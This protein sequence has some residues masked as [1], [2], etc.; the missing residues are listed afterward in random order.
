MD[1]SFAD[2]FECDGDE[3]GAA[4]DAASSHRAAGVSERGGTP[5]R[6]AADDPRSSAV[7]ERRRLRAERE[8]ASL[9]AGPP[10]A[11]FGGLTEKQMMA[12]M[13]E[14]KAKVCARH[15]TAGCFVSA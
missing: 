14:L 7:L 2:G 10:L 3:A 5:Q 6:A 11:A 4:R 9:D 12:R 13:S 15:R 1:V 8:R